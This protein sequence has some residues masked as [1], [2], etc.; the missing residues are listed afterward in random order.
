MLSEPPDTVVLLRPKLTGASLNVA[1][2]SM[3]AQLNQTLTTSTG[4]QLPIESNML[5]PALTQPTALDTS[6]QDGTADAFGTGLGNE[7]TTAYEMVSA[8]A[9]N[10]PLTGN[11]TAGSATITNVVNTSV[12]GTPYAV[13]FALDGP[14][15]PAGAVI[16]AINAGS[17]TLSQAATLTATGSSFQSWNEWTSAI[18]P[19]TIAAGGSGYANGETVVALGGV[20]APAGAPLLGTVT[21]SGGVVTGFT[22][23]NAIND[24][25]QGD[26]TDSSNWYSV[27]PTIP[28]PVTGGSG[29]G[30][31]LFNLTAND[32]QFGPTGISIATVVSGHGGTGYA[33]GDV[34]TLAPTAFTPA[35]TAATLTVTAVDPTTH[36]ILAVNV[37]NPGSYTAENPATVFYIAPLPGGSSGS[38]A[39]LSWQA[40]QTSVPDNASSAL[41]PDAAV[42]NG[43]GYAVGDV[44]VVTGGSW[45]DT[46]GH[47]ATWTTAPILQVTHYTY[48]ASGPSFTYNIINT[49]V[50]S[51]GAFP[52]SSDTFSVFPLGYTPSTTTV[53]PT[54]YA[55]AGVNGGVAEFAAGATVNFGPQVFG[56]T[57]GSV[58]QSGTGTTILTGADTYTG[59][60]TV[61]TGTL[62]V[63]GSTTSSTTVAAPATLG[64]TGT[65]S[66]PAAV[67]GTLTAGNTTVPSTGTKGVR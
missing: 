43:G 55:G 54:T 24:S 64:G 44:L 30:N 48:S 26:A 17:I 34:L 33:V 46:A 50:S 22:A 49:P 15:I 36:A 40:L 47:T 42:V 35:G 41:S 32:V 8:H 63:N 60:T 58:I 5:S 12:A 38:G 57:P 1:S 37:T 67:T 19:N 13:G 9:F 62:L 31:P 21:T 29:T 45:T 3:T 10:V 59:A 7:L 39:I 53:G 66:A 65:I 25:F 20:T 18:D 56:G 6:V 51:T 27:L 52:L 11:T 14:G 28:C 4:A 16:I 23:F 61:N 2:E